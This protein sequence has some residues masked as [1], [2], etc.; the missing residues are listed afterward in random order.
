MAVEATAAVH[1]W[2]TMTR[3][4]ADQPRLARSVRPVWRRSS[5]GPIVARTTG[6]RVTATATLTS[7]I[8]MPAIPRLRRNGT[9]SATSASSEM[10]T[11][12]PLNTTARPACCMA[13]TTAASLVVFSR[14][15]SSRQRTTTSSA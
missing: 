2:R 8:S 6:S 10:A 5:R 11:V 4:Q 7:G 13:L 15:R 12:L 3:A 9:G 14:R 1:R